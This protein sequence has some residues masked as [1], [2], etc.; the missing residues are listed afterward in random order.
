[1][2]KK[3]ISLFIL[4]Y[5][6]GAPS[7]H[8]SASDNTSTNAI[9]NALTDNAKQ[10]LNILRKQ[11]LSSTL[12]DIFNK[13]EP[14]KE[15]QKVIADMKELFPNQV[16][17][18]ILQKPYSW[19]TS[20]YTLLDFIVGVPAHNNMS[21]ALLQEEGISFNDDTVRKA[22]NNNNSDIMTTLLANRHK[23]K[24]SLDLLAFYLKK[25]FDKPGSFMKEEVVDAFLKAGVNPFL[26][27]STDGRSHTS[28]PVDRVLML[29]RNNDGQNLAYLNKIKKLFAEYLYENPI[30]LS[31]PNMTV[32]GEFFYPFL[33]QKIQAQIPPIP[34]NVTPPY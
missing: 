22:M 3:D 16:N 28:S 21:K 11:S 29:A 20:R 31:S 19:T 1:M 27:Q 13:Q 12:V 6:Y 15:P 14:V 10:G 18:A 32:P 25:S 30:T 8:L 33:P 5:L 34:E 2:K 4:L 9:P 26:E 7:T 17:E 23:A 24:L